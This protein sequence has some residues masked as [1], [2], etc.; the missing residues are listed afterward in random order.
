LPDGWVC[1]EMTELEEKAS[2]NGEYVS[3][4]LLW[5]LT[6]FN[7]LHQTW[8][9]LVDDHFPGQP[10]SAAA[11]RKELIQHGAR[12]NQ[13]LRPKAG[14]WFFGLQISTTAATRPHQDCPD[15]WHRRGHRHS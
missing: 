2:V 7:Q 9:A 1:A 11:W 4:E 15:G 14:E 13:S 3:E 12:Y 10:E 5:G 6:H 8:L